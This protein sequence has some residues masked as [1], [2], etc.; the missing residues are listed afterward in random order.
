M[1]VL[2]ECRTLHSSSTYIW[3][4]YHSVSRASD[5]YNTPAAPTYGVYI[6]QFLG[7][8]VP[9]V[10]H[11]L[12]T[13][14]WSIYLS[15]SRLVVPKVRHSSSTH[16]WSIYLLV[17]RASGS[18]NIPAAPRYGVYISQFLGLVVPMTFQQHLY[19]EYISLSLRYMLHM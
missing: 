4:I 18:Y 14:I 13:Y 5:S 11:S 9:K 17:F 1:W 7:L 10:R 3:S 2:L 19:M 6:S 16:I 8:V 15:V 12:S